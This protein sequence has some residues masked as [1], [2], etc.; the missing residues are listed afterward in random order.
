[1]PLFPQLSDPGHPNVPQPSRHQQMPQ[2]QPRAAGSAS[3][4]LP[5]AS[6]HLTLEGRGCSL[7]GNLFRSCPARTDPPAEQQ[8][9]DGRPAG[10]RPEH[11]THICAAGR[12][13]RLELVSTGIVRD[14]GRKPPPGALLA[15]GFRADPGG[16]TGFISCGISDLLLLPVL[17][18]AGEN[19]ATRQMGFFLHLRGIREVACGLS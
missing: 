9:K 10:A 15:K 13:P 1:M 14:P 11:R 7:T 16:V 2:A 8:S 3:S 17:V 4:A 18:H 19:H 5:W 6:S 12:S